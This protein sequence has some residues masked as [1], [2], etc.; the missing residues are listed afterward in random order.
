MGKVRSRFGQVRLRFANLSELLPD[1]SSVTSCTRRRC[2]VSH[3]TCYRTFN[4]PSYIYIYILFSSLFLSVVFGFFSVSLFLPIGNRLGKYARIDACN[5]RRTRSHSDLQRD[6]LL[7]SDHRR[8]AETLSRLPLAFF[9]KGLET[10]NR[11][12]TERS[13]YNEEVFGNPTTPRHH[14]AIVNWERFQKRGIREWCKLD[15]GIITGRT[16]VTG[17]N[18][19]QALMV[20][21]L[22][23]AMQY[24]NRIPWD[25]EYIRRAINVEPRE[26]D[27]Q[28]GVDLSHLIQSNFI[29]IREGKP[30]DGKEPEEKPAPQRRGKLTAEE[31]RA[32]NAKKLMRFPEFYETY[33]N[34]SGRAEAERKWVELKCDDNAD[35]IISHLKRRLAAGWE[36]KNIREKTLNYIK[37]PKTYL[38]NSMWE[39]SIDES[40]GPQSREAQAPRD[41]DGNLIHF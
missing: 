40:K 14:I 19:D 11:N 7:R 24:E 1:L 18:Y 38:T 41:A 32:K 30:N 20:G 35:L 2:K 37:M 6:G 36:E 29:E 23:L 39:D 17:D 12:M 21:L 15:R 25:E 8:T 10:G 4:F 22:I 34:K 16:W 13:R 3:R 26:G 31:F 5:L 28:I 27:S 33:P 9:L